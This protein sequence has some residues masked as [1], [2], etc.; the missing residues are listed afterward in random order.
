[1]NVMNVV[2][3]F[4]EGGVRSLRQEIDRT[5]SQLERLQRIRLGQAVPPPL[6]LEVSR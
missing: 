5:L 1:M 3:I 6:R 2:N 4:Q